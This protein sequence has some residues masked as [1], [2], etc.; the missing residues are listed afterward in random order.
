MVCYTVK[1]AV[2]VA[3]VVKSPEKPEWGSRSNS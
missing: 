3:L 2:K 1:V